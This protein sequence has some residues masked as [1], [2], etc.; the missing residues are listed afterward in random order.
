MKDVLSKLAQSLEEGNMTK[1]KTILL[2][3]GASFSR[4]G[5]REEAI[6]LKRLADSFHDTK[7]SID[8]TFSEGWNPVPKIP[9]VTL[10]ECFLDEE[11]MEVLKSFVQ[12]HKQE[13]PSAR[14]TLLFRNG[15]G[16]TTT[17]K[18]L[19]GELRLPFVHL[20]LSLENEP[21]AA[22]KKL[23]H[24]AQ[25]SRGLFLVSGC[26]HPSKGCAKIMED[27]VK[28]LDLTCSILVVEFHSHYYLQDQNFMSY[29]DVHLDFSGRGLDIGRLVDIRMSCS[30][31]KGAI[32]KLLTY[33]H[34][35]YSKT[36]GKGS[37]FR[38][39][40]HLERT[41]FLEKRLLTADDVHTEYCEFH[42]KRLK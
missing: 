5:M 37:Y 34:F 42:K 32:D 28:D 16:K 22:L 14:R 27:F 41:S 40:D 30:L 18:A 17:A 29:F 31:D 39:L 2:Q 12:E 11:T 7:T 15:L 6:A 9:E 10:R 35:D 20:S 36:Y 38:F 25:I 4:K 26:L 24:E 21:L 8:T 23:A 3:E 33:D 13:C 19:A 1:V